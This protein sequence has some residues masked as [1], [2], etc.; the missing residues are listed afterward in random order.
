MHP[1]S[2]PG[3]NRTLP[4][5]GNPA[6]L[7]VLQTLPSWRESV[8]RTVGRGIQTDVTLAFDGYSDFLS[9]TWA[10]LVSFSLF[11]ISFPFMTSPEIFKS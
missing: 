4:C 6:G 8:N 5:V 3:R 11:S 10:T 1:L 7:R 9:E 2:D